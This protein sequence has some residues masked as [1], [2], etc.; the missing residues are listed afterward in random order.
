MKDKMSLLVWYEQHT[1]LSCL[2]RLGV[3]IDLYAT[4]VMWTNVAFK[5]ACTDGLS[6]NCNYVEVDCCFL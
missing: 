3:L 4:V 5:G 1:S 6:A 2:L